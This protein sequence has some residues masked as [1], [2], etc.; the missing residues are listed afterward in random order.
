MSNLSGKK[1]IILT[2]ENELN[3]ELIKENVDLLLLKHREL[4]LKDRVKNSW[5]HK[6]QKVCELENSPSKKSNH[7][8]A[9][10]YFFQISENPYLLYTHFDYHKKRKFREMLLQKDY[11]YLI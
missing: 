10:N 3:M 8:K 1:R 11:N 5:Q 7:E 2:K 6:K 4:F 9:L